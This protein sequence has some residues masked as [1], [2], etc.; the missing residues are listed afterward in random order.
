MTGYGSDDKA[1]TT[2]KRQGRRKR[3]DIEYPDQ[4]M[5]KGGKLLLA[6]R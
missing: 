3:A 6:L 2:T 1:V 5:V 4:P